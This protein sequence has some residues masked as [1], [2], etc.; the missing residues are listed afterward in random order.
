[1]N[2]Q[3]GVGAGISPILFSAIYLGNM[4]LFVNLDRQQQT[5]TRNDRVINKN[6]R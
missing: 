1:M 5:F 4:P 2:F 6:I 3:S